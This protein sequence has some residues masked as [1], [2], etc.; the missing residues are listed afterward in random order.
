MVPPGVE[1]MKQLKSDI[2]YEAEKPYTGRNC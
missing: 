1:T 2:T